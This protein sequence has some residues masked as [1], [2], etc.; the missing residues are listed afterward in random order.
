M[1]LMNTQLTTENDETTVEN[2]NPLLDMATQIVSSYVQA[3]SLP[4]AEVLSMIEDVYGKLDGLARS[5]ASPVTRQMPAVPVDESITDDYIICLED[6]KPFKMLKK[7][8]MAVY[9]MTPADYRTKWGL[10]VDY[11]MVAPTY[12]AKRQELAKKSGLG[13]RRV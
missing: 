2:N 4:K 12:A 8:L 7:H 11:P 5:P 3:N 10:P 13:R 6:G 9:G 1:T